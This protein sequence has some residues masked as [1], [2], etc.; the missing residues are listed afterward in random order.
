MTQ[1]KIANPVY[2]IF[3]I[4]PKFKNLI[5]QTRN[6]SQKQKKKKKCESEIGISTNLLTM[7]RE[8]PDGETEKG[9]TT[10]LVLQLS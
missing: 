7:K 8:L 5:R 3:P 9:L 1:S 10:H 2:P 4:H 6:F